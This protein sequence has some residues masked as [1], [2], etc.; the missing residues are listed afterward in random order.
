MQNIKVD[1]PPP[2]IDK[3]PMKWNAIR[4]I[5]KK[6]KIGMNKN[7]EMFIA[8][9]S[10]FIVHNCCKIRVLSTF[11]IVCKNKIK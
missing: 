10:S 4:K 8:R 7:V 2:Q 3:I 9:L 11:I 5:C 1:A 6:K